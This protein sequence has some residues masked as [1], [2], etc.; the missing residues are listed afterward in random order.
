MRSCGVLLGLVVLSLGC[1]VCVGGCVFGGSFGVVVCAESGFCVCVFL[2]LYVQGLRCV[3]VS[4]GRVLDLGAWRLVGVRVGMTLGV[5]P[6]CA[7]AGLVW[8]VWCWGGLGL[9]VVLLGVGGASRCGGRW[10]LCVLWGR[11]V[12]GVEVL[13]VVW[14]DLGAWL[15]VVRGF[16]GVWSVWGGGGPVLG[17]PWVGV[18]VL[19]AGLG[20]RGCSPVGVPVRCGTVLGGTYVSCGGVWGGVCFRGSGCFWVEVMPEGFFVSLCP[21]E[22]SG[23]PM[24]VRWIRGIL[25]VL[26]GW[27][28]VRVRGAFLW[29]CRG[30][31]VFLGASA[32]PPPAGVL[33]GVAGGVHWRA[34]EYPQWG[35]FL[36]W[37]CVVCAKDSLPS[38]DARHPT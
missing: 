36:P 22:C 34:K 4:S 11:C 23:A 6:S 32:H 18:R 35:C 14:G 24:C 10:I 16:S 8:C 3:R 7:V 28:A 9:G 30:W 25:G 37:G 33:L 15:T 29:R 21:Q 2:V 1:G 20:G 27:G 38:L 5:H 19:C 31:G 26:L 12:L 13:R 17:P